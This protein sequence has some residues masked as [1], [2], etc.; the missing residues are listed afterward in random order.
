M[1]SQLELVTA[2]YNQASSQNLFVVVEINKGPYMESPAEQGLWEDENQETLMRLFLSREEAMRY[3][4]SISEY[5]DGEFRVLPVGIKDL[6]SVIPNLNTY[7]RE[8]HNA[9]LR[10]DI[11]INGKNRH[12]ESIDMLWSKFQSLH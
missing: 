8:W 7:A 6:W 12:P 2:A 5:N 1:T 10:I 3:M 11:S 9:P 4:K